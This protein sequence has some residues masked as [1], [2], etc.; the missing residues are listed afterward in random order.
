MPLYFAYGTNMDADAM[1]RRCPRSR[2][3]GPARLARHRLFV[4]GAGYVSVR[5]DPGATV[6]GVLYDLAFAD[7][8][9]L[10]KYEEV[11]A[12][13]YRKISQPV[14]RPGAAA[15]RALVY[16]G[17]SSAPGAPKPGHIATILAAARGWDMPQPYLD[18]LTGLDPALAGVTAASPLRA[19]RNP[20]A[21]TQT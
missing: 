20:R 18:A 13:L 7:L 15:V 4:M 9:A 8:A 11:G 10:D 14:L 3:L 5:R 17:A 2:P 1:R 12:G 6:H 16:V 21:L 19:I